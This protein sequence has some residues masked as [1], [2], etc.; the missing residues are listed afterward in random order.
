MNNHQREPDSTIEGLINRL[1]E[2]H[3]SAGRPSSAM[4]HA[5]RAALAGEAIQIW[6]DIYDRLVFWT[7]CELLGQDLLR[8]NFDLLVML[9]DRGLLRQ[10]T[11]RRLSQALGYYFSVSDKSRASDVLMP[12]L[13]SGQVEVMSLLARAGLNAPHAFLARLLTPNATD[14]SYLRSELARLTGA[15][16]DPSHATDRDLDHAQPGETTRWKLEAL[17]QVRAM[18]GGGLKKIA[19]LSEVATALKRSI[20]EMQSWE[21]DLVKF[22][23]YENDLFCAELAGELG[24]ELRASHYSNIRN[25]RFYGSFNGVYNL[26][27]ASTLANH[28]RQ[29]RMSDIAQ[30]LRSVR[31]S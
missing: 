1:I 25:Y 8:Q 9:R 23:D 26:E 20:D 2:I 27:R 18:V 19:A 16:P 4:S 17:R 22:G 6:W 15:L 29:V 21:R 11:E 10:E 7:Q 5:E 24:D 14:N 12:I 31:S 13:G 3:R 28:L 30:G